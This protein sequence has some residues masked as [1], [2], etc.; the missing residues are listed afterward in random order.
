MGFADMLIESVSRTIHAAASSEEIMNL[1]RGGPQGQCFP[2]KRERVFPNFKGSTSTRA[3]GR[4][5]ESKEC[6]SY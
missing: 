5:P 3:G 6:Y 2:G 1:S 4:R